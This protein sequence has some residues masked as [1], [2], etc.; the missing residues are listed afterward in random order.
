MCDHCRCFFSVSSHAGSNR[1]TVAS[2]VIKWLCLLWR[3]G[4]CVCVETNGTVLPNLL[5]YWPQSFEASIEWLL[6]INSQ[7][8]NAA[9][10]KTFWKIQCSS[11]WLCSQDSGLGTV[12]IC[13][14][15]EDNNHFIGWW[16]TEKT[17]FLIHQACTISELGHL[18]FLALALRQELLPKYGYSAACYEHAAAL[19]RGSRCAQS[20]H[21]PVSPSL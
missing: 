14:H 11:S 10:Y 18:T 13:E 8:W 1:W 21:L 15:F 20:Y 7:S 19:S 9:K 6:H 16:N 2:S 3:K 17:E 5:S 12:L 4:Y